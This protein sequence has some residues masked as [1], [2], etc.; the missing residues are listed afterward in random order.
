LSDIL[1]K[2]KPSILRVYTPIQH[3]NYESLTTNSYN[4]EKLEN[5]IKT[6][7]EDDAT[8]ADRP[9]NIG[10]DSK[11]D[12]NKKFINSCLSSLYGENIYEVG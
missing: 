1:G 12:I 4:C 8:F 11:I 10:D 6:L 5:N 2:D 3:F 9:E 7:F